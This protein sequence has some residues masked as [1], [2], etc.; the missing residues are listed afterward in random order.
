M[1]GIE[2]AAGAPT[3]MGSD[4]DAGLETLSLNQT[5][6]FVK[7]VRL[8][9]PLDGFVFWVRPSLVSPS[10]LYGSMLL[11]RARFNQPP[12][13]IPATTTTF[14]C[15]GSLHF[16]TDIRQE[17]S[18]NYAASRVIFTSQEGI[19]DLNDIDPWTMWIG[20]LPEEPNLPRFAF[21]S[22]TSRYYQAGIW[23]YTGF[24]IYPDMEPQ[25]IDSVAGFDSRGLVVSNSL[26]AWLALNGYNP[27]FG[28]GNPGFTLFPSFLSPLN[29]K[30]P[31]ATVHIPPE[32]TRALGAAPRISPN[33]TH[34]QLCAD[35]VKV[36]LW[37]IRN[38]AA[39][40]FQ[41][42][43]NQY[44]VNTDAIGIMNMPVVRDEKR[45]QSELG[46][47]AQKKSIEFE[48]SYY[49]SRM[50]TISRQIIESAIPNFYVNGIGP[51][52]PST[53]NPGVLIPTVLT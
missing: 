52:P 38:N 47:I 51:T 36:T 41:D 3:P 31:F 37:G 33:S 9:L 30:P 8:V 24:A 14:V 21:S 2:E 44:S 23:H 29:M 1:A 53:F 25:I 4:L 20:S 42:C 17:E 34:S 6:T 7:Y 26:P 5:I 49:Q 43:V 40:D 19:N 32:S 28:F 18:E 39:L 27:P 12:S 15:K 35:I 45:T 46:I 16:A 50:N 22:Q 48:V 13:L 11:N 10:A